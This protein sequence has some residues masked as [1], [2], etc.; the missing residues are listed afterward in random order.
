MATVHLHE[1]PMV[2]PHDEV[3]PTDIVMVDT[4]S[5]VPSFAEAFMNV[6]TIRSV[7]PNLIAADIIGVQPLSE[8]TGNIH[9]MEVTYVKRAGKIRFEC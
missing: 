1:T 5:D 8:P 4:R 9:T 7:F 6:P 2:S 3:F